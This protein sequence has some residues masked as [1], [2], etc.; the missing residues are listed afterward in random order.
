MFYIYA[1]SD[2]FFG[3]ISLFLGY[4]SWKMLNCREEFK[5]G[6]VDFFLIGIPIASGLFFIFHPLIFNLSIDAIHFVRAFRL[7][8]LGLSAAFWVYKMIPKMLSLPKKS[9]LIV[10]NSALISEVKVRSLTEEKL[11]RLNLE[12]DQIVHEKTIQLQAVI[13]N[14]PLAMI[15]V[16]KDAKVMMWNKAA[17]RIFGW[18]D[19]EVMGNLLPILPAERFEEV[20][21]NIFKTIVRRE[22]FF[23]EVQ[24]IHKSG[25]ILELCIWNAPLVEPGHASTALAMFADNSERIKLVQDLQL[26][27]QIA[28]TANQTKSDF[29]ARISHEIRTPLNAISGF[30]EIL[31]TETVD[32]ADRISYLKTIQKN[33]QFLSRLINDILD[34]SKIEAGQ[35]KFE[36]K[37]IN[38]LETI[39]DIIQTAKV[40]ILNKPVQVLLEV[41]A[42]GLPICIKTDPLRFRQILLNILSNSIKFTHEGQVKLKISY[43]D[44]H[45]TSSGP[46]A[47]LQIN[48]EDTG[49][50]MSPQ[51]A[52]SLFKPYYQAELGTSRKFGGTGLGL[53]IAKHLAK[54]M[55]GDIQLLRSTPGQGC[56][57]LVSLKVGVVQSEKLVSK[58]SEITPTRKKGFEEPSVLEGRHILVVDD[59][60]DNLVLVS[61]LISKVGGVVETAADGLEGLEKVSKNNYD[62]VLMDLEMPQMDGIEALKQIRSLGIRTHVIA[63]TGHAYENDRLRC[64]EAGFDDHVSK[65]IDKSI[66]L[67]SLINNLPP[68]TTSLHA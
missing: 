52:G 36:A 3:F 57:F 29:L 40:N 49:I 12:L 7:P 42:E 8:V 48:I 22:A 54:L 30:S 16:D 38:L 53:S 18:K 41:A 24:R 26:A 59:S 11:I 23:S 56:E 6:I 5:A 60:S 15:Q 10:M 1:F 21:L 45:P 51:Q 14:S 17:E 28:L 32:E 64:I 13:D 35:I 68:L 19:F 63:L 20:K 62:V 31:S 34:F 46:E 37:E 9:E 65:P 47:Q 66:L 58:V 4:Q 27:K 50:G 67:Q 2:L 25:R 44:L 33:S 39:E 61:R 43:V 55:G